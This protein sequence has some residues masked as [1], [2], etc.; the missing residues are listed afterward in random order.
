MGR[1]LKSYIL[2]VFGSHDDQDGYTKAIGQELSFVSDS[3][4][5]KYFYSETYCVFTFLSQEDFKYVKEFLEYIFFNSKIVYFLLPYQNDNMSVKIDVDMYKHLFNHDNT[6]NLTDKD[7]EE[8]DL[9][10]IKFKQ[11]FDYSCDDDFDDDELQNLTKKI[12]IPTLD[13]IL[14]KINE[15]GISSITKEELNLLK[16]YSN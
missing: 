10:K 3:E 7:N 2:F 12:V 14:D 13:E 4:N 6:E 8:F 11:K 5:V 15:N 1:D 16:V 9:M